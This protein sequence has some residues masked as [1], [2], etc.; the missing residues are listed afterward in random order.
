V[1]IDVLSRDLRA[2]PL[3]RAATT[4]YHTTLAQFPA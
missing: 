4:A 2:W 3:E 1:G